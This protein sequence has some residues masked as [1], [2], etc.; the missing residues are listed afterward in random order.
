MSTTTARPAST[1]V[2]SRQV[3]CSG[4]FLKPGSLVLGGRA[5]E[6]AGLDALDDARVG[7]RRRVAELL[8]L[9]DVAEQATHDLARARLREILG[10]QDRLRL[11]DRADRL[12]HVV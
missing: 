1:A 7:E 2:S 4:G 6:V 9:G 12:P 8:V 3:Q 11:R 5:R 10:E